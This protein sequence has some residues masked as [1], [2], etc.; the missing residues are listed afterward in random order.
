MA[1]SLI[2]SF[3]KTNLDTQN[4]EPSGGPINDPA[5]KF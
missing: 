1:E 3:D 2:N 4:G 5:I